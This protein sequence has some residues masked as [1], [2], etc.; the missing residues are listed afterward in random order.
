[1]VPRKLCP[2][3]PKQDEKGFLI[4]FVLTSFCN[5]ILN[6]IKEGGIISVQKSRA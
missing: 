2:F 3:R 5:E 6:K 4:D 1:M